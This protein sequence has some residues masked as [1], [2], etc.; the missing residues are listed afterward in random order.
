MAGIL[1][2]RARA[3]IDRDIRRHFLGSASAVFVAEVA[4]GTLIGFLEVGLRS[5]AD[6]CNPAHPVGYVEGWYV[7]ENFRC[8]GNGSALLRVAEDWARTQGCTEMASDTQLDNHMSQGAHQAL[9]FE[10]VERS[11]LYRKPL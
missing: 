10:A 3:G 4:G 5:H 1:S 2:G 7:A 8:Q 9:G 11:I 6:H